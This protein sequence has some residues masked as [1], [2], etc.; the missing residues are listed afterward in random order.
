MSFTFVCCNGDND[1][2]D[3]DDGDDDGDDLDDDNDDFSLRGKRGRWWLR[4]PG[5]PL[6]EHNY[7]IEKYKS[8]ILWLEYDDD[9]SEGGFVASLVIPWGAVNSDRSKLW[10]LLAHLIEGWLES[11]DDDFWQ[12]IRIG[13]PFGWYNFF[14]NNPDHMDLPA[15]CKENGL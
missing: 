4:S 11:K 15:C 6:Q 12:M 9:Q 14:D 3:G 2:D 13:R 5:H 1:D 10:K 7:N 8:N